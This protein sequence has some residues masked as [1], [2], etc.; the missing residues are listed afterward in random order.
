MFTHVKECLP[1]L[2]WRH[3]REKGV[4]ITGSGVAGDYGPL[5]SGVEI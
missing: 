5:N 2:N 3:I 4:R 1:C